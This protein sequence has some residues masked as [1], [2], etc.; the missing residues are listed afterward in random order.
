MRENKIPHRNSLFL[1]EKPNPLQQFAFPVQERPN[2]SQQFAFPVR[3]K[4]NP[5]QQFAFPVV[6]AKSARCGRGALNGGKPAILERN[7]RRRDATIMLTP[8]RPSS[9]FGSTAR[10][11]RKVWS[12]SQSRMPCF[13]RNC[14]PMNA[15]SPSTKACK[16]AWISGCWISAGVARPV[17]HSI[18]RGTLP[19]CARRETDVGPGRY[20]RPLIRSGNSSGPVSN[21]DFGRRRCDMEAP[22]LGLARRPVPHQPTGGNIR[23]AD[24]ADP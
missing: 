2:P 19:H 13:S 1:W 23:A 17:S 22:V 8:V 15:A 3:E 11:R 21:A 10:V 20:G 16:G 5:S 24:Y 12:A 9:C 6:R 18:H 14:H 4:P 7:E